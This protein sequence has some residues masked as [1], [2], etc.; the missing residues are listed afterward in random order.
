MTRA[1]VV[2]AALAVERSC[3]WEGLF[4]SN[5]ITLILHCTR[6]NC[7]FLTSQLV[8]ADKIRL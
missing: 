2:W 5:N 1:I 3:I 4:Q 7:L 8:F 6:L